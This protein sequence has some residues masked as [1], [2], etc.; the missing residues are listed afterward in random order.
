MN[1]PRSAAALPLRPR[2]AAT[3][4]TAARP[5]PRAQPR[6]AAPQHYAMMLNG[7]SYGT[8]SPVAP[9]PSKPFPHQAMNLSMPSSDSDAVNAPELEHQGRY[10]R[11]LAGRLG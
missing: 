5:K 3:A 2:G 9:Q 1:L 11:R 8:P 7:M 6:P 10:R 4:A